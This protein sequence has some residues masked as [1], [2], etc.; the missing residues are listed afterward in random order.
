MV[1]LTITPTFIEFKCKQFVQGHASSLWFKIFFW[2]P[3]QVPQLQPWA[4]FCKPDT[5]LLCGLEKSLS[6]C[7]GL[8]FHN[9]NRKSFD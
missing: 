3:F 2:R 8:S 9:C 1:Q 5:E 6:L 7:V 4:E